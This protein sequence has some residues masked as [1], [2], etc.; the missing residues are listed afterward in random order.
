MVLGPDCNSDR[1][2]YNIRIVSMNN[3]PISKPGIFKQIAF[4]LVIIIGLLLIL[5]ILMQT[6]GLI[7]RRTRP[8]AVKPGLKLIVCLGDSHTYGYLQPEPDS[9]PY[10]LERLLNKKGDRYQVL[11]LGAIG[12]NSSQVLHFLPLII[13]DYH[14]MII[15]LQVGTN[16][17]WNMAEQEGQSSVHNLLMRIKLYKLFRLIGYLY[18]K[19]TNKRWVVE[20]RD[21]GEIVHHA[22][23]AYE[24]P[25]DVDLRAVWRIYLRDMQEI[26][27]ICR[28]NN[29]QLV[30]MNYAGDRYSAFDTVNALIRQVA[31]KS[32]LPLVDNYDYF[33]SR[34]M[35]PDNKLDE[36]LYGRLFLTDPN[37]HLTRMGY[38]WVA[39]NACQ[40]LKEQGLAE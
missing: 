33:T 17:V 20:F 40:V 37:S 24:K 5:E 34:M 29:V 4:F 22:A 1:V 27:K 21:S 39:E 18:L 30:L 8:Q 3:A 31:R 11:N 19:A 6:A 26:I 9:Y 10:Q 36:K 14:P 16:N 38:G 13:R 25:E 23:R 32:D 28:E 35:G 2:F 7:L 15:I 12:V